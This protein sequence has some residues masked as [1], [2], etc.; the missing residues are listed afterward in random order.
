MY[1]HV[2]IKQ[3][4]VSQTQMARHYQHDSS[5]IALIDAIPH[6]VFQILSGGI[7]S[8]LP[9]GS[10]YVLRWMDTFHIIGEASMFVFI[11]GDFNASVHMLFRCTGMSI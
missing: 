11:H 7:T 1:V 6:E 3:D 10:S 8:R 9:A 4:C 5:T 2:I